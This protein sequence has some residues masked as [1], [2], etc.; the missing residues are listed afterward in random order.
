MLNGRLFLSRAVQRAFDERFV[1]KDVR[2]HLRRFYVFV[3]EQFLD[4]SNIITAFR[5]MRREAAPEGMTARVLVDAESPDRPLHCLLDRAFGH[6]V[7]RRCAVLA[8]R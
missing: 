7:T 1:L 8:F 6:M 3:P 2:V 5:Q 4:G